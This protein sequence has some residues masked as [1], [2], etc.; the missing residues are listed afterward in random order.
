MIEGGDRNGGDPV[1]ADQPLHEQAVRLVAYPLVAR[2][3]EEAARG[4]E[5][6]QARIRQGR[7]QQVAL[8]L[9]EGR[10]PLIVGRL[11][12]QVGEAVLHGGVGGEHG[13]LV[14][15]ADLLHQ[16]AGGHAVT[17][18][19]AGDVEGL[20]EGEDGDGALHQL[21]IANDAL[22][23][24]AVEYHVLVHLVREN[25][26]V[27]AAHQAGEVLLIPRL[28]DGA[29]GVVGGV[30]HYHAGA[31]GDAGGHFLPGDGKVRR[32]EGDHHRG[33]ILQLDHGAVAV[34]RRLEHDHLVPRVHQSG[35]GAEQG[36]AGAG[37]DGDLLTGVIVVAVAGRYLGRQLFAQGGQPRHG[38]ILVL[39]GQH[40]LV[41]HP[42]ELGI[43]GEARCPLGEVDAGMAGG[44]IPDHAEDGGAHLGQF[45]DNAG[46]R[47]GAVT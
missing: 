37:G 2:Q 26:D 18:P 19:P 16:G 32:L 7:G 41:G 35:D 29:G 25:E 5:Q 10:Q 24:R 17:H 1:I 28:P 40:G 38:G 39:P 36:L 9:V 22:V 47:H 44:Q 23:Q 21:R 6:G 3:H 12:Q 45:A 14:H 43:A 11:L 33:G 30:E 34:K 4:G 31:R 20:A 27:G 46:G 13:E 15:L 42:D 8:A